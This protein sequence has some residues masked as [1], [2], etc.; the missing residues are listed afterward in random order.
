MVCS[1]DLDKR[2]PLETKDWGRLIREITDEGVGLSL[3]A[4]HLNLSI[5]YLSMLQTG[6]KRA[7]MS[8]PAG[9]R[10]LEIHEEVCRG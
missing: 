2:K 7:Q 1:M 3:L 9:K 10:L 8:Y 6:R 5:G 4:Y